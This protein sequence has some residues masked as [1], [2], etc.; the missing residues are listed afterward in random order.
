MDNNFH[1]SWPPFIDPFIRPITFEVLGGALLT[2][3]ISPTIGR[4]ANIETRRIEHA[5]TITT[6]DDYCFFLNSSS[7]VRQKGDYTVIYWYIFGRH[8]RKRQKGSGSIAR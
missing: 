7:I 5:K 2:S 4:V 3:Y 1:R 6:L 8:I